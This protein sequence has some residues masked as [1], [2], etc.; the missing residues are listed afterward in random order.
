MYQKVLKNYISSLTVKDVEEVLKK[1]QLSY[2]QEEVI[3]L[4]Q[5]VKYHYQDLLEEKIEVFQELKNQIN[6]NLYKQLLSYYI[7]LKQK[8]IHK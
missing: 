1:Y 6:P 4:Y 2:K 8:Y 5:F 7:E 3:I